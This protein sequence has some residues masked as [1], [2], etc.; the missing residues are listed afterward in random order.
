MPDHITYWH[1]WFFYLK[2]LNAIFQGQSL[3]LWL[4]SAQGLH[5]SLHSCILRY[6]QKSL[7]I[8]KQ[9][10]LFYI[11]LEL[12]LHTWVA[13]LSFAMHSEFWHKPFSKANHFAILDLRI[14][15]AD[16]DPIDF[17]QGTDWF[18]FFFFFL[19][20]LKINF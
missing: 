2:I 18:F 14:S 16:F 8:L 9:M 15:C 19:F 12:E 1:V 4:N 10:K 11:E 5:K 13:R 7:K 20:S 17:V 3:A 6:K